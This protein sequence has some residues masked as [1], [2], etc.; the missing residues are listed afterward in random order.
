MS[1]TVLHAAYNPGAEDTHGN[2]RDGWQQPI[3]IPILAF[4]PGSTS[5][6]RRP[7]HDRVIT[8]PKLYL[9]PEAV[10]GPR[11]RVTIR[12]ESYEVEGETLQWRS[13]DG[14][15]HEGNIVTLRK[16]MG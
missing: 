15:T 14:A 9:P 6:P 8:E 12:G 16:V 2:P 11:D 10:L 13:P 3:P 1:E 5:E 4:D 7:G